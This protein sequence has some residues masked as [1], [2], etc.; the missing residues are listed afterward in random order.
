MYECMISLKQIQN[1]GRFKKKKVERE[2]VASSTFFFFLAGATGAA[3]LKIRVLQVQRR[4]FWFRRTPA[5]VFQLSDSCQTL[6]NYS[7]VVWRNVL[8]VV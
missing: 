1:R 5:K 8:K 4:I 3:N 6:M 7:R 2:W